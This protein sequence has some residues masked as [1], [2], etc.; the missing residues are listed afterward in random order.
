MSQFESPISNRKF[1]GQ[2][3]RNLDVPD[4]SG[5]EPSTTRRYGAINEQEVSEFQQRPESNV[6]PDLSL[7]E[8]EE[9][10][11]RARAEKIHG[12]HRL[13]DGAK[14][15]IDML[16]GITRGT[17]TANIENNLYSFKTLKSKEMRDVMAACS[18]YDG[19]VQFPFEMRRQLLARSLMQIAGVDVPQ[20]IGSDLLSDK[21][22]FIDDADDI[23]LNRL[24]DEYLVMIQET[25]GRYAIK[26]NQ[27]AQEV[28]E[29]LKK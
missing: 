10:V 12:Q 15:R 20:F 17:H 7:S 9:E 27:E 23:L 29:D 3:M 16:I 1:S 13:S 4:E 19:T 24:Y 2:P 14:R 26:N 25:R 28:V 5:Q 21:L 22:A 8:I 11:K 6:K 18:E